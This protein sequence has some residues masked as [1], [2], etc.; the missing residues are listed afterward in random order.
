MKLNKKNKKNK[1]F[2]SGGF[3]D[4]NW[5]TWGIAVT[6]ICVVWGIARLG[7]Y[8]YKNRQSCAAAENDV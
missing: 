8:I 1:L 7:L 3:M 5:K 6:V 4:M 2:Q